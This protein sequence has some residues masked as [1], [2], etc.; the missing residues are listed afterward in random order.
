MYHKYGK[1][2]KILTCAKGEIIILLKQISRNSDIELVLVAGLC[3][4]AFIELP[5]FHV[6]LVYHIE[7]GWLTVN[8]MLTKEH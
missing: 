7:R 6:D 2:K 8:K 1:I 4:V 5:P 3:G